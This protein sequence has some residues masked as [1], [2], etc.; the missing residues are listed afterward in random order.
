MPDLPYDYWLEHHQN[1]YENNNLKHIQ[2]ITPQTSK[3]R[4]LQID[5]ESKDAFIYMVSSSSTTGSQSGFAQQQ[6]DYFDRI[7]GYKLSTPQIVGFGIKDHETF[8]QATTHAKG[9][10]I[11]SAFIK[12]LAKE[13][14][15]GIDKFIKGIKYQ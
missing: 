3:E 14:L 4:I 11:G 1:D 2:L 13:G 10:I 9:A 12:M 6:L 8:A 15:K 5:K 7:G